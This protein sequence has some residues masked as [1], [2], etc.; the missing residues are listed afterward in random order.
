MIPKSYIEE[1]KHKKKKRTREIEIILKEIDYYIKNNLEKIEE[2]KILEFGSGKGL[3]IQYLQRIVSVTASDIYL[4]SEIAMMHSD[5]F[6]RCSILQTPFKDN[7]FDI[8][9]SNH[10]LEH[11]SDIKKAFIEMKR[12][13]KPNCLFV[14]LVPTNIWLLLSIPTQY[15]NKLKLILKKKL[16]E[17][18]K[19]NVES[20]NKAKRKMSLLPRG[21]GTE[22]NYVKC[23]KRFKISQWRRLFLENNFKIISEKQLLLY[24]PSEWPIVP[25]MKPVSSLCSSVLFILK[26]VE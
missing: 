10:V 3:Q 8:I 18:R 17:N 15:Y 1:I 4:S 9:F 21:H 12:I 5:K 24:A 13:G 19:D 2:L 7:S 22:L 16:R 6:V 25:T 20:K 14:F 11:I 23:M 26:K